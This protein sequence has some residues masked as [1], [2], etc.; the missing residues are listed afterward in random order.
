MNSGGPDVGPRRRRLPPSLAPL[1]IRNYLLYWIGFA[2]S[3]TGRWIEL[4]GALWLVAGLANSPI[5]LGLLGIVRAVPAIVLSPIAGVIVDRVDQRRML[6]VTQGVSLVLSLAIGVLVITGRIELWHLYVQMGLQSAL[7]AFDAA[8]R[9]ALFP[10]LVPREL[11]SHAVT[12]TI[13]AGRTAKFV[14]PAIG[15][16]AI[17]GLGV[18]APFFLNA[19]SFL[20]LMGAVVAMRG[21]EGRILRVRDAFL[22]ELQEGFRYIRSSPVLSGV[23][24]LE[25]AFGV[26]QMNEVMIT[27]VAREILRTGPEG[28]GLLLSAPALGSLVGVAAFLTFGHRRHQGRFV[29]VCL[30]AYVATLPVV[31]LSVTFAITFVALA[32]VGFLDSL[33]TVTRHS[34]MQLTAPPAMRGRVMA[35]MGTVTNGIGPL[36]Q[37]QSGALAALL[38][39]P[40]AIVVAAAGLA[41]TT[42][43]IVRSTPS[44]WA[45]E[46]EAA[47]AP[48]SVDVPARSRHS[49]PHRIGTSQWACPAY[50]GT[51]IARSSRIG[52]SSSLLIQAPAASAAA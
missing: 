6:F 16:L 49:G 2:T 1:A 4:T 25:I 21:I 30:A 32:V 28:L 15:G 37:A 47:D 11:L 34:M 35:N 52:V 12:L 33:V 42:V 45:F 46:T 36:A 23:L 7:Q 18:A 22:I 39:P 17:A 40:L 26:L 51:V 31:A 20:M 5:L 8:V 3:N 48:A 41:S 9:Q 10:R 50:A 43:L 13:T 38:G 19:A 14:G 44:L 29:I 27:I 24:K